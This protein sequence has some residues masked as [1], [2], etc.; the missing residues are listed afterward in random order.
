MFVEQE[1]YNQQEEE[2]EGTGFRRRAVVTRAQAAL[3]RRAPQASKPPSSSSSCLG[4]PAPPLAPHPR[5]GHAMR[6]AKAVIQ[7]S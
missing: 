7:Q 4:Y 2:Y 6:P 3:V 1:S 5:H